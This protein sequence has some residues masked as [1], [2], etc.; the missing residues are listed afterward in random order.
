MSGVRSRRKN[1]ARVR[2]RPRTTWQDNIRTWTGLSL[3]KAV[4]AT[5]DRSHWRKI[6]RDVAKLRTAEKGL[7]NRTEHFVA[8]V[9][10]GTVINVSYSECV[11]LLLS[12]GSQ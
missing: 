3:V 7:A 5:E 6:V 9:C 12:S 1:H 8:C 11:I 4:R 10:L 2:G